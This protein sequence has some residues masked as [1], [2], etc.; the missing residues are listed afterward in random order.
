MAAE[1]V[2][3]RVDLIML[4]KMKLIKDGSGGDGGGRSGEISGLK[5]DQEG[6]KKKTLQLKKPD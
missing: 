5:C 3:K 2:S 4:R 1:P 6:K